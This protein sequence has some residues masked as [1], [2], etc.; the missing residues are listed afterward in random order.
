MEVAARAAPVPPSIQEKPFSVE[1][2]RL[3]GVSAVGG[4]VSSMGH[5]LPQS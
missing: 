4:R 5:L 2:G 3:A 1:L